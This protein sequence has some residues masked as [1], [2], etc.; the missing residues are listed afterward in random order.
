M[1]YTE[2]QKIRM[3]RYTKILQYLY[4]IKIS[5]KLFK[6][7]SQNFLNYIQN[8]SQDS[9]NTDSICI[10][11]YKTQKCIR[12]W[13][14]KIKTSKT[15]MPVVGCTYLCHIMDTA[16]R[17]IVVQ[18]IQR[19]YSSVRWSSW[20]IWSRIAETCHRTVGK[21][22]GLSLTKVVSTLV[23]LRSSLSSGSRTI[24]RR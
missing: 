6:E 3:K 21:S 4:I 23:R 24:T 12:E 19:I 8:C 18:D 16:Y 14:R 15:K 17:H 13:E 11:I 1:V 7:I 2:R 20:K 10:I 9:F 5:P 22:Y